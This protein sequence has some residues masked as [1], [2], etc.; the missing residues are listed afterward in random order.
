M[1]LRL[2]TKSDIAKAKATDRSLEIAEGV[3]LAK[4]VDTLREVAA[5][6]ESSLTKFR[7]NTISEITKEIAQMVM[8]RDQMK[9]SNQILKEERERL[10]API[11]LKE[12]WRVVAKDKKEVEMWK[13]DLLT[14]EIGL[15]GRE[16]SVREAQVGFVD[17]ERDI[18]NKEEWIERTINQT[19][20]ANV[21]T[22][23]ILL[24]TQ[25][26]LNRTNGEIAERNEV[27]KVKENEITAKEAELLQ[28]EEQV[29]EDQ[30]I[31]TKGKIFVADRSKM[32][33]RGFAE[34]RRKQHG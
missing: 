1:R 14:R 3:K 23:R 19:Q 21:E 6:E 12:E 15:T 16:N 11:D 31:I 17:R 34:L 25:N 5:N 30:K 13:E 28:R 24:E 20:A 10:L 33:E 4:R 9:V 32:L 26:V 22:Q 27:L 29:R 18:K 2:L 8:D 7:T